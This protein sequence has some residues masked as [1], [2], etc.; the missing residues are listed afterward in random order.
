MWGE[1]FTRPR[2]QE[3]SRKESRG[4][5]KRMDEKR[6][7]S[8]IKGALSSVDFVWVCY[9]LFVITFCVYGEGALQLVGPC[10]VFLHLYHKYFRIFNAVDICFLLFNHEIAMGQHID[11]LG[12]PVYR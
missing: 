12:P 6:R 10:L 9:C 5:A 4:N 3:N 1:V 8:V 2:H 7:E 11:P